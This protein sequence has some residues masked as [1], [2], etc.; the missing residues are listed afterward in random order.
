MADPRRPSL[1][2]ALTAL[3]LLLGLPGPAKATGPSW[4][5]VRLLPIAANAR[6]EVL[7]RTWRV[8]SPN[9]SHALNRVATG[10]LVVSARGLWVEAPH[11]TLE[12]VDPE[13]EASFKAYK[14]LEA[15]FESPLAWSSPPASV[16]HLLAR[17]GFAASDAVP[18]DEGK[19]RVTWSAARACLGRAC[20]PGPVAQRTL[21]PLVGAAWPGEPL[22]CSFYRAGVAV[23]RNPQD[24][25]RVRSG[26]RFDHP[27]SLVVLVGGVP[28]QIGFELAEVDAIVVIDEASLRKEPLPTP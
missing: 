25:D 28:E 9:G 22:T 16:R 21:G 18:P 6:G 4:I 26:S 5:D 15:E 10:W 17:F 12:P 23:V 19:G 1:R 20:T 13:T 8:A 11:R 27:G 3:F 24:P 14:D 7:V 2:S